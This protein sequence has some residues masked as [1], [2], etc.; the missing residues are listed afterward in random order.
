MKK[1]EE[2]KKARLIGVE[3]GGREGRRGRHKRTYR[4]RG[5]SVC[6]KA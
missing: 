2:K 4:H 3:E 5:P 6:S 1:L